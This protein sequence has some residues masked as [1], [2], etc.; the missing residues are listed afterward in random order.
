ME[1]LNLYVASAYVTLGK[2]QGKTFLPLPTEKLMDSRDVPDKE[3]SNMY[4]ALLIIWSK[5]IKR[6]LDTEPE[7]ILK[8]KPFPD[9]LQE[10]NFWRRKADNLNSISQQLKSEQVS[11]VVTYL[12]S[13]KSTFIG[14][15][16]RL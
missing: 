12:T 2:M 7:H 6:V 11:A 5:Q 3:K 16:D 9:P 10:L 4:E 1:K 14:Q 13:S 8:I 15:Y